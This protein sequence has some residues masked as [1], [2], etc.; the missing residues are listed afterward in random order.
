MSKLMAF[1]LYC[2]MSILC[3]LIGAG[4]MRHYLNDAHAYERA[5]ADRSCL[6]SVFLASQTAKAKRSKRDASP[7]FAVPRPYF[8]S[9]GYTTN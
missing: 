4:V 6:K 9:S 2:V 8:V 1:K 5:L 3:M 7:N